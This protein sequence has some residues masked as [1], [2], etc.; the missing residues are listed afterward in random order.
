MMATLIMT[1][2]L[3][4]IDPKAWFADVFAPT[5]RRSACTSCCPGTGRLL[6]RGPP[7]RRRSHARQQGY[8]VVTIVRVAKDLGEDEEWLWDV[9]NGMDTEDGVIWV[10]GIGDDQVMAFTDF[11]IK[12]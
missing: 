4:D 5:C 11:D 8:A 2:R 7:P 9:A 3:N 10:Y 6:R 12:T 1:A